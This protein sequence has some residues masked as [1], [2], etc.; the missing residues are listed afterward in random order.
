MSELLWQ[1]VKE[2]I[3][4]FR[5]TSMLECIYYVKAED[6]QRIMFQRTSV[7]TKALRN[8]LGRGEQAPLNSLVVLLCWPELIVGRANAQ[9]PGVSINIP[10]EKI[11]VQSRGLDSHGCG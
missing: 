4:K 5:E 11:W 7:L 3:K 1:I 6:P 10:I 8:A 2:R 9:K